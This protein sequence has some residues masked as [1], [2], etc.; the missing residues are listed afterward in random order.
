[1]RSSLII[2]IIISIY[3]II[4]AF[5]LKKYLI[6]ISLIS[7]KALAVHAYNTTI[8]YNASWSL[9][10]KNVPLLVGILWMFHEK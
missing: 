5:F 6:I 2:F 10:L 4:V 1:M 7:S 8:V 3:F 9:C